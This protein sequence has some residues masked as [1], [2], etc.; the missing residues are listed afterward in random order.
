MKKTIL[1]LSVVL[2]LLLCSCH[3]DD[4]VTP[5]GLNIGKGVFVLNQG[6]YTY[7]NAS[8]TF[9]DPEADTAANNMFYRANGAPIGD[10][11]Q[12][13]MLINGKL[14][15]VVNNSN[16]IYKVDAQT[17]KCDTTQPYLLDGFISPRYMLPLAPNKVYVS[18][19]ASSDLYIVDPEEMTVTGT[20]AM[21]KPTE[22]MVM[23]GREVYVTNWS[24]Y[25]NTSVVNNTVMVVDAQ[26]DL[27]VHEIM[28]GKEPNGMVVDRNGM[29]WVLCEGA[30]WDEEEEYPSL[31]CINPLTK[32]ATCEGYF[33][34]SA[35]EL[36]IDPQG[37]YLYCIVDGN[38]RRISVNNPQSDDPFLISGEGKTFF[39][40]A[41]NPSNGDIYVSDAKNYM[42][43]GQ[44]Y[45]YS[46][47]GVLL[48]S[49]SAGVCPGYYLFKGI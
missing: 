17:L 18:D 28:V 42:V 15:I 39:K 40:I 20:I 22:T 36:A 37:E 12:S 13:L 48:S 3:P 2:S 45:R 21:G 41:V 11:G 29:I 38:V 25:Y 34:S 16:Y 8:L 26:N 1:F 49:F 10:V 5:S 35:A 43:N 23:V 24:S 33:A 9:Y 19:L 46:S 14:Y 27:K 30:F 6:T 4:P 44:V 47:D 7:A 32:K 31:W